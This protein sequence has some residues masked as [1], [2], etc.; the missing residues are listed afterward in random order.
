MFFLGHCITFHFFQWHLDRAIAKLHNTHHGR[1]FTLLLVLWKKHILQLKVSEHAC[2]LLLN[3]S[4]ICSIFVFGFLCCLVWVFCF[5][6]WLMCCRIWKL[7]Y[8]SI[9]SCLGSIEI[10]SYQDIFL[11]VPATL[12]DKPTS[13]MRGSSLQYTMFLLWHWVTHVAVSAWEAASL[14]STS[15]ERIPGTCGV[16][17][18]L[19]ILL[20]CMS[21]VGGSTV[22]REISKPWKAVLESSDQLPECDLWH[23]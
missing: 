14:S 10:C 1:V 13:F 8:R 3:K 19:V 15:F 21:R 16:K 20:L 2:L 9:C 5:S 12:T 4:L 23:V 22:R 17:F 11:W 6:Y 7:Y 18:M